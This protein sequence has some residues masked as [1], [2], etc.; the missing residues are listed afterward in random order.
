MTTKQRKNNQEV[1]VN[2]GVA[3]LAETSFEQTQVSKNIL[4]VHV[5]Y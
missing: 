1:P 4:T 2:G 3:I 5:T